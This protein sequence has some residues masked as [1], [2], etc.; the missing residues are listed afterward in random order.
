MSCFTFQGQNFILQ[1]AG[2][3]FPNVIYA[4]NPKDSTEK[5]TMYLPVWDLELGQR[6]KEQISLRHGEEG[7]QTEYDHTMR[8]RFSEQTACSSNK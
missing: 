3:Y 2:L 7:Q 8:P 4:A 1:Y 6:H 5:E